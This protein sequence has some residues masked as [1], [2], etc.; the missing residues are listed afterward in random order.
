MILTFQQISTQ[1]LNLLRSKLQA[2]RL[3]KNEVLMDKLSNFIHLHVLNPI[4]QSLV[5]NKTKEVLN[6]YVDQTTRWTS[7]L[8]TTKSLD[9][10]IHKNTTFKTRVLQTP[11]KQQPRDKNI[12]KTKDLDLITHKCSNLKTYNGPKGTQEVGY[13]LFNAFL[14]QK[15]NFF[16][17]KV[18]QQAKEAQKLI[19]NGRETIWR[20][21]FAPNDLCD[22]IEVVNDLKYKYGSFKY[23]IKTWKK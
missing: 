3:S 16:S 7:H 23:R 11:T 5:Q 18:H 9:S 19:R 4:N 13:G 8:L 10:R 6:S 17:F 12:H 22:V 15:Y 14:V 20:L 1:G 21:G 2:S